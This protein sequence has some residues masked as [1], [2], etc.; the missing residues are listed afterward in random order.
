[1]ARRMT[2]SLSAGG[3]KEDA[4]W[5]P[6]LFLALLWSLALAWDYFDPIQS[7]GMSKLWILLAA[8]SIGYLAGLLSFIWW[9]D[10]SKAR[11]VSGRIAAGIALGGIL[12]LSVYLWQG[13]SAVSP[14][15]ASNSSA[16]T[17]PFNPINAVAAVLAVVLAVMTLIAT[18]SAADA[19]AEA[20]QARADVLEALNIRLLAHASRL[21]ER[22]QAAKVEAE[23]LLSK[24]NDLGAQDEQ[25]TRL[26]NLCAYALY[27]LGNVFT[28][29]HAWV[30]DPALT[31]AQDLCGK[32]EIPRLDIAAFERAAQDVGHG[33]REEEQ[34]FRI[35]HWQPAA[36]LF[37]DVLLSVHGR[38]GHTH[39]AEV[40]SLIDPLRELRSDLYRL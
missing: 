28:S 20:K 18:K 8:G 35:E 27:R 22:S 40:M 13:W 14:S 4:N 34:H 37:E 36:R 7:G 30:L 9:G 23:V 10:Q 5:S 38:I 33:L 16:S 6:L 19:H 24:A 39:D 29:L 15:S 12:S 17:D 3:G 11:S 21:L 31:P 26:Y 25:V 1:M 2:S 32:A